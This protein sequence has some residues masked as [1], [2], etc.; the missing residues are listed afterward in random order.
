MNRVVVAEGS[1]FVAH[2]ERRIVF[3]LELSSSLKSPAPMQL[4]L[5]VTPDCASES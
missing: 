5:N 3:D 4:K 1:D 2:P